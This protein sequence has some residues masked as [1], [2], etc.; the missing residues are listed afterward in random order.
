MRRAFAISLAILVV[1]FAARGV[2]A[3]D[4]QQDGN[5][6]L[7]KILKE[8]NILSEDEYREIKGQLSAQKSDVDQKLT[9]LDRS[10]SDYLAKAG[11]M[12]GGN[13]S[14]VQNQGVTFSS[15]DGAWAVFFGGLFQ[16]GYGYEQPDED[17]G[18]QADDPDGG[19]ALYE[20]RFDFGGK[21]FDPM[22]MFYTQIITTQFS[23]GYY[24][25]L[26]EN[27][28][29]SGQ[30]LHLLD[31]FV[32]YELCKG[33]AIR[34]GQFKVP[35]GRQPLVDQSD[36]AFGHIG[37]VPS[38]F[39]S[40]LTSDGRDLGLMFHGV[41]EFDGENGMALEWNAGI[42]NGQ[43]GNLQLNDSD[44]KLMWGLRA[45]FYPMGYIPY[46]EGSWTNSGDVRFGIAGS[47]FVD[48]WEVSGG[49][50][51]PQN[52]AWEVD[53][54]LTWM[55]LY[56]TGEYYSVNF[57]NGSSDF[58][59]PG[60]YAQLGYMILPAQLEVFGRYGM[61]DFDEQVSN[62]EQH[63]WALGG[64]WY[65]NGHELKLI[66]EIGQNMY[67]NS[68]DLEDWFFRIIFQADW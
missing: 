19:F 24:P 30:Y 55:G 7:L 59:V 4:V 14:Y 65:F 18:G 57:D 39:R 37:M 44:H 67:K 36:R 63:E 62:F 11:D 60:W 32:N 1:T 5:D 43:G 61:I 27:G 58:D 46:V 9:A 15:G 47:I 13:T 48:E 20:N 40:A 66:T 33:V 2:M 8:R 31:A 26:D 28:S 34:A 42:W 53:A 12:T 16:F 10:M 56:L 50:D 51:N 49:G 29:S 3:Q 17:R 22:L 23:Q 38:Y 6:L 64:A 25:G 21:I 52:T 35:Y 54:V 41:Y 45:G 68:T